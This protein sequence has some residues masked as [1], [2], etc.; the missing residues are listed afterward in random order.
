MEELT[1]FKKSIEDYATKLLTRLDVKIQRI[2]HRLN[3][4]DFKTDIFKFEKRLGRIEKNLY[5]YSLSV[6]HNG[7]NN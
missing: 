3:S 2:E 6:H 7:D 5:G 4:L 1:E